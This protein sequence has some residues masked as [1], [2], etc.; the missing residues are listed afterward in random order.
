MPIHRSPSLY[1]EVQRGVWKVQPRVNLLDAKLEDVEL[2][3][4]Q[5]FFLAVERASGVQDGQNILDGR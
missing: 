1:Q 5:Y 4:S 3:D 2:L